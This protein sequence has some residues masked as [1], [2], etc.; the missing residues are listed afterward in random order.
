MKTLYTYL[1]ENKETFTIIPIDED[2]GI[3]M[4]INK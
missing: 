2:D 4:I 1:E 3:M